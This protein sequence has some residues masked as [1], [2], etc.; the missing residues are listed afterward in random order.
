[1]KRRESTSSAKGGRS[2]AA[3]SPWPLAL[4]FF[5]S[6]AAA[7]VYE[8]VWTRYL[9]LFVGH[10]AY[11]QVI[12]LVIFMGGMAAGALGVARRSERLADPLRLY[13]LV[14]AAA[15]VLG[16]LFHPAFVALTEL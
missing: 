15:G 10:G 5:L 8:S 11:A 12:V 16:L 6:G 1:M 4:A 14:E 13:A 3:H 2:A 7:L 9:G